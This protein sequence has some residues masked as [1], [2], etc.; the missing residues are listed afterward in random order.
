MK[1]ITWISTLL[2][3][4][5]IGCAGIA[6][7]MQS[8]D[9]KFIDE[10]PYYREFGNKPIPPK[11]SIRFLPMG[12]KEENEWWSPSLLPLMTEMD[13][14]IRQSDWFP[15][16]AFD[17]LPHQEAPEIS[18]GARAFIEEHDPEDEDTSIDSDQSLLLVRQPSARWRRLW[19]DSLNTQGNYVVMIHLGLSAYP[20]NQKDWKGNKEVLLGSGYAMDVPWLTSMDEPAPVVHVVGA[21][22]APDG[23]IVRAGAE[24]FFSKNPGGLLGLIG[25]NR[26]ID[27]KDIDTILTTHRRKDFPDEPLAWKTAVR[28]LVGRLTMN[29]NL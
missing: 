2:L 29:S 13:K 23:H 3:S 6:D 11:A 9:R 17:Q 24:G 27:D 21:L 7:R 1:A 26:W 5:L 12:V 28:E 15:S 16:T 8:T 10:P 4:I 20:V 22:L 14:W 18:F 25:W 19:Q